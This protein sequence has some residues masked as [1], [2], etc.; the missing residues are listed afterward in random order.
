M[1][2]SAKGADSCVNVTDS[3]KLDKEEIKRRRWIRKEAKELE[4]VGTEQEEALKTA[5]HWYSEQ[6][7]RNLS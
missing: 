4:S 6:S 1:Q 7:L 2:S 5:T 3:M